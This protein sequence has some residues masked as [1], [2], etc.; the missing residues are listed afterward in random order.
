MN[1]RQHIDEQTDKCLASCKKRSATPPGRPVSTDSDQSG[2]ENKGR[3]TINGLMGARENDKLR[4][5]P[6]Y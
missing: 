3:K 1:P 4:T 6:P 2:T 5:K